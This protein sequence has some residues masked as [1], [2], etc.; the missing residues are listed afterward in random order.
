MKVGVESN[1]KICLRN[2]VGFN[3]GFKSWNEILH[4]KIGPSSKQKNPANKP[5]GALFLALPDRDPKGE[6]GSHHAYNNDVRLGAHFYCFTRSGPVTIFI[7]HQNCF[8][9]PTAVA[10]S[11]LDMMM[12]R[13]ATT[14]GPQFGSLRTKLP[15]KYAPD[16]RLIRGW[17]A[18]RGQLG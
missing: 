13:L 5:S 7:C 2:V 10:S 9:M 16:S 3:L 12:C 11:M 6:P 18:T 1:I 17:C 15:F 14:I 4:L 8:H